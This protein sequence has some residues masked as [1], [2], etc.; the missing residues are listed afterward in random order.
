MTHDE[1]SDARATGDRLLA[2]L[3]APLEG[4]TSVTDCGEI[5]RLN[6]LTDAQLRQAVSDW[7]TC[8]CPSRPRFITKHDGRFYLF[9]DG[10]FADVALDSFEVVATRKG[11]GNL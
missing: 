9:S 6:Q 7:L 5:V 4:E 2:H 3:G 8:P 10:D 1:K 11:M